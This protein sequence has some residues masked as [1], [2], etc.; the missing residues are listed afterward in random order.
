MAV[1]YARLDAQSLADRIARSGTEAVTFHFAARPGVCGDGEHFIRTGHNSYHGSFSGSGFAEAPCVEGPVQVRLSLDGSRVA[2]VQAWVGPLRDRNARD[3]GAVPAAEAARYLLDV[4]QRGTW[5][6]ADK[7]IMPAVLA[8][9]A[10]V[11]PTLLA[12]AKSPDIRRST[13]QD[14]MFW[15]SRYASGAISGHPNDPL[16]DDDDSDD[17]DDDLKRHAVFVLS[18]LP[19]GEGIPDLLRVARSNQSRRVRSQALFWLGQSGDERA[20][21]LFESVLKS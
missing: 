8:D 15:L 18:Q 19:N 1:P 5:G 9:S 6:S 7:A 16:D 3:L 17:P 13:R 14:A 2:R 12:I 20:I 21:A 10:V 11:W 4:A